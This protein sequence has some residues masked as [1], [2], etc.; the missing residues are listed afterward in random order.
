MCIDYRAL[1]KV[2]IKNRYPLPRIDDL[3]DCLKGAKYFTCLDLASGYHQVRISEEDIPKTAF[4]TPLGHFQYKVLSF[5]LTNAPATFQNAMNDMLQPYLRKSALVYLDDI[6]VYSKT[7]TEHLTHLREVLQKLR[8]S[9]YY[10][11]VW[12]CHFGKK[13][14][15]Y[16]GHIISD[17]KISV[18]KAK[19]I[20]IETWPIPANVS[21]VRSLLGFAQFFKKF[22]QGY[23]SLVKPLTDLTRKSIPFEWTEECNEAFENLKWNL[24]NAPVL[25]LPDPEKEYVVISDAS[26]RG[27]GAVLL[28]DDHPVAFE[29][30]KLL[31]SEENY[32]TGDLEC[33]AV[34]KA[35]KKW[36]CYLEGV[37]FTVVTDHCPL[38]FIRS[39]VNLSRR[40]ARWSEFFERFSF[41]WEYKPGRSNMADPLSRIPTRVASLVDDQRMSS[42]EVDAYTSHVNKNAISEPGRVGV[43]HNHLETDGMSDDVPASS[44]SV[45]RNKTVFCQSLL[46]RASNLQVELVN[47]DKEIRVGY[48]S[49]PWFQGDRE[50]MLTA[51]GGLWFL[52][53]NP[54]ILVVPNVGGVRERILRES[55]DALYSGHLGMDRTLQLIQRNFWWPGMRKDVQEYVRTCLSCQ[56]NKSLNKLPLGELQPIPKPDQPWKE[57]GTDLI[58]GLP[59]TSKGHDAIIVFVDTFTKMVHFVPT[60]E[61]CSSREYAEHFVAH[62]YKDHG[63][64]LKIFSDRD[65]RFLS[66]FWVEVV[67]LLGAELAMSTAYHPQTDGQSERMNRVLEDM[68]R[69][70]ISPTQKNWEELLPVAEFAINNAVQGST[71]K[72]PFELNQGWHP[73]TPLTYGLVKS[74]VPVAQHFV[75][76]LNIRSKE[77]VQRMN[78]AQERQKRYADK[79]MQMHSFSV[80]DEVLLSTKNISLKGP[81]VRKLLP[82]WVGPFKVSKQVGKVAY[83]LDLPS[84]MKIHNVFHVSL[85]KP[86]HP[87]GRT[88]PPP[89]A[90]WVDDEPEYEVEHILSHRVVKRG[91]SRK[92]EYLIKWTGYG[93]EHNSWEQ[94]VNLRGA[95]KTLEEYWGAV[96]Q[97]A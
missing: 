76:E 58:V 13:E 27:T 22:I 33:L 29:S 34:Y 52:K 9:K 5:G 15:E 44:Q 97:N 86:Y 82:R 30:R 57:I 81:G 51:K 12:K 36:R 89:P 40:Q 50:A 17:G 91:R 73:I 94:E 92:H 24:M 79:R 60:T 8:E 62:V 72:T 85:L 88:Q 49:D 10:C 65:P 35:L 61:T 63:M 45:S 93:P 71:G 42:M 96:G 56:R 39:Q 37:N 59:M 68:L 18:D 95:Q 69:H 74:N 26:Q 84:N 3:F 11:R 48:L 75:Q 20:A 32:S 46:V 19:A 14:I 78:E 16:L 41:K 21:E 6:L 70:Y 83:E 54:K 28:Q 31:P 25:I 87:S 66:K 55:H 80:G 64:P 4:R 38:T 23:S 1:N 53:S 67:R 77:A 2:T 90:V 47:L 7:W 43:S